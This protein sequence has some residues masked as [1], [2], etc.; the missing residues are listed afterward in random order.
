MK[1]IIF[2]AI[3]FGA[4]LLSSPLFLLAQETTG[5]EG[6]QVSEK[7]LTMLPCLYLKKHI[8]TEGVFLDVSSTLLNDWFHDKNTRFDPKEYLNFR[9]MGN[10]MFHYF[11]KQE[12]AAIIPTLKTGDKITI[13]GY[14]RSCADKTPWVEVDSVEKIPSE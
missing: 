6:V 14:V 5:G 2:L 12:K 10:E 4:L 11:I 1:K 9:T 8:V 13:S 3:I 7:T